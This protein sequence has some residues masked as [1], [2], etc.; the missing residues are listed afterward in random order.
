[1]KMRLNFV[2]STAVLLALAANQP[3]FAKEGHSQHGAR[4]NGVSGKG[5]IGGNPSGANPAPSK[6]NVSIDAEGTVAPPVLPPRGITQQ[7]IQQ[8]RYSNSSAKVV[9]P[10][11]GSRGQVGAATPVAPTVRN[12]IGQ[13]VL[14]PKN[15]AGAQPAALPAPPAPGAVSPPVVHGGPAAP[16]IASFG[17]GRVNV[18]NNRGSVNGTTVIRPAVAPSVIGGPAKPHSGINGTTVQSKH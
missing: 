8:I 15:F 18:A 1:M 10:A 13:P 9:N 12:A 7:H 16:P 11:N 14:P 6:P 4:N 2:L 5:A 3:C 17:T